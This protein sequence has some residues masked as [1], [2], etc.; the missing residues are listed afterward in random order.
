MTDHRDSTATLDEAAVLRLREDF[1][2]LHQ[3]IYDGKPL[4]YLD[5]AAT[6]QKPRMVIDA[7]VEYY[8][9]YN[10]NVHRALHYLGEQATA[11][12]EAARHKVARFLRVGSEKEIIFTRGT[13]EGINLVARA[14]GDG[15]VQ[16]GD[17]LV[18][19]AM[20][21]HSNLVPWQLCAE[22][23]GAVLKMVPVT[24]EGVLDMDAYRASLSERTRLVAVTHMSNVL[25]TVN[26]VREMADAAHAVG[27]L[28]LVDAAQ[29]VPH[30]PV[31]VTGLDADFLVFSAHK[32]CGPTG[33]GV[34]YGK[35]DLLEEMP[36][37][38]G[39]G[40]M[41]SRVRDESS[42]WA[43]VPYKFEAGTPNIADVIGLGAAIDYLEQVGMDRI[44]AYEQELTA[45]LMAQLEA[46][47]GVRIF[48]RAPQRGGAVSFEVEGIH[49]HDLS[50]Y[51]DQ[52]G[53]AIRAG[54]LCAQPLMR[55]LGVPAVSRASV[56]FYNTPAE[57]DVLIDAIQRARLFFGHG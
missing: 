33:V 46:V 19:T 52:Q 41:I 3:T 30:M 45:L 20:E 53:V 17:E 28:V 25:G 44:H 57:V 38:L 42:T 13:T 14:W 11:R 35:C 18:V 54:H 43:E 39:G 16:A 32:L 4:V 26:P 36:P 51:V 56:Y 9:K 40:E 1:P 29:S 7:L 12:Y 8:E 37:F 47:P 22:R 27:A 21:H 2:V 49:P 5:N 23:N 15:A 24:A 50:Q 10:A 34:L 48:G 6:S 31:D 55:R